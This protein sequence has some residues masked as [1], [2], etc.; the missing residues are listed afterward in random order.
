[1]NEVMSKSLWCKLGLHSYS[2]R[3]IHVTEKFT[4][5]THL[6]SGINTTI[7]ESCECGKTKLKEGIKKTVVVVPDKFKIK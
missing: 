4:N 7:I 1:M 2:L 3:E 6:Q 5:S